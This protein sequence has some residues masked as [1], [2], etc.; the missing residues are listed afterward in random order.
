MIPIKA[1]RVYEA[2][3]G[4]V[5]LVYAAK[6]VEYSHARALKEFLDEGG[7]AS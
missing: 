6:V 2:E 5:T 7:T 4:R 3:K 1:K